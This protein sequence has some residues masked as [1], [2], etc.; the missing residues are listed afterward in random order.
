[1][2]DIIT[3]D[4]H[5]QNRPGRLA[6]IEQKC[7]LGIATAPERDELLRL[8]A[9]RDEYYAT[10]PHAFALG[11][12]GSCYDCGATAVAGNHLAS[13]PPSCLA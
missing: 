4:D 13:K 6:F 1:V 3:W 10:Q 5:F 11:R 2:T 7:A 8:R 12:D 9:V